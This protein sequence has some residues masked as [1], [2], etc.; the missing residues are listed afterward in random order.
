LGCS[1]ALGADS[2]FTVQ[3]V[4]RSTAGDGATTALLGQSASGT[5]G[6]VVLDAGAG[7]TAGTLRIGGAS[8]AVLLSRTGKTVSVLGG[9]AVADSARLQGASLVLGADAAM[10]VSRP[11]H[12]TQRGSSTYLAAQAGAS[13]SAGG[14]MVINAGTG[15]VA[16]SVLI[17][18]SS[19]SVA[20]SQA[21]KTTAVRGSL[22][23]SSS[24]NV[25]GLLQ[26]TSVT[27]SGGITAAG[28]VS[29]G[30]ALTS[31]GALS[32][33]GSA[34]IDGSMA[35]VGSLQL[36]AQSVCWPFVTCRVILIDGLGVY[37]RAGDPLACRSGAGNRCGRTGLRPRVLCRR[38]PG[39][40]R[41]VLP[42][43]SS[44]VAHTTTGGTGGLSGAVRVG[45]ASEGVSIGAVTKTVTVLG[46]LLA[47]TASVTG[48]LS[49]A[50]VTSAGAVSAVTLVVN[51]T[52]A[53]GG[54]ASILGARLLLGQADA[55][56]SISRVGRTTSPS[57]AAGLNT[58]IIGQASGHAASVG[59]DLVL[60]VCV[61]MDCGLWV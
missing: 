51:G 38:R 47:N 58:V 16:G 17:G 49:A 45:T 57:I 50:S 36:G 46:T 30:G 12:S 33:H 31:Q 32:V 3:R 2:A 20:L 11:A 21:G 61:R 15:A 59:G 60:E 29:A 35:L 55:A 40:R 27:A 7:A 43:R 22:A 8:E 44:A 19:E 5:G 34:T 28:A 41:C 52:A 37:D 54:S 24:L 56:F 13:G 42:S 10:T 14:D 1:I 26:A 23:V 6:S 4:A 9:L 25:T 39:P 18:A 53:V 48:P